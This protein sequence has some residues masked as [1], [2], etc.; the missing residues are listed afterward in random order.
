M[1]TD[2]ENPFSWIFNVDKWRYHGIDI[3]GASH[4]QG[5]KKK[6]KLTISLQ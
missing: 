2:V 5:E 1:V 3:Q 6:N 4:M